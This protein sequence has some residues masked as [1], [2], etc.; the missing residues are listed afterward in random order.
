MK[1]FK[2]LIILVFCSAITQ[3]IAEIY[4]LKTL[5]LIGK[6]FFYTLLFLLYYL[7]SKQKNILFFWCLLTIAI[8]NI[9]FTLEK[10]FVI[11]AVV[12]IIHRI[13][14]IYYIYKMMNIKDKIPVVLSSI[15]FLFLFLYVFVQ[16]INELQKLLYLLVINIVLISILGGLALSNYIMKENNRSSWLMIC[17]L[18]FVSHNFIIYIEKL[19]IPLTVLRFSALILNVLAYYTFYRFVMSTEKIKNFDYKGQNI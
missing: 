17:I 12:F 10:L 14:L 13:I 16:E 18:F 3:I 7:N 5:V 2:W 1:N 9:F 15:P 11:G 19:F 8:S 4:Q 6:L